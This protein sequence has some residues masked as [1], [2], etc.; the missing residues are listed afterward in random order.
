MAKYKVLATS[1][2]GNNIV[3]AGDVIEYEGKP[4]GNLQ[5]IA[6]VKQADPPKG[7]AQK[8]EASKGEV[9]KTDPPKGEAQKAK[10]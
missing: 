1:F 7:E 5:R 8:G 2:I 9:P 10:A 6:E 4:S 3:Q